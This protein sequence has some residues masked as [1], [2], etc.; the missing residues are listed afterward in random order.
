MFSYTEVWFTNQNP[1]P[2]EIEYKINMIL[3]VH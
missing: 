2:L 3:V 1:E